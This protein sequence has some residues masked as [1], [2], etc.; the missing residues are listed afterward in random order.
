MKIIILDGY[1]D[2]PSC[3]GVPPYI[4]PY[5]RY[6][7]GAVQDAGFEY[8]YITIDEFRRG[9]IKIKKMNKAQLLVIVGGAV[10]PGKYLRGNPASVSEIWKI[11]NDY[12]GTKILGGPLAKFGFSGERTIKKLQGMFDYI[13]KKDVDAL[14]YDLLTHNLQG[15]RLRSDYEWRNWSILGS[16]VIS[17]HPDYP[18][19]LI[20]EIES[21][22]VCVR[23]H[24]GGCAFCIEPLFGEPQFREVKDI[25]EEVKVLSNAGALNFR[26]GA[27]SCIFTYGSSEVGET[28]IPKPNPKIIESLLLG[29]RK[30][31]PNLQVLHTDNANP[32]VIAEHPEESTRILKTLVKYCTSGNVLALGMESADPEVIKINNLNA[33]PKQ[34][35]FAIELINKYGSLIG[36][37]GMFQFLKDI[38]DSN[39]LLRRINIRQVAPVRRDFKV[40]TKHSD[41]LR[42]KT[43]VREEIDHEMIKRVVPIKSVLRNVYIEKKKGNITFGRQVGTYPILVGIPYPISEGTFRDVIITDHGQRSITGCQYP[44]DVNSA[45]LLALTCLPGIGKKRAARIVRSRPFSSEKEFLSALDDEKVAKNVI[46]YITF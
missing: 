8:T 18:Q 20:I 19:P 7:A 46:G 16:S 35:K 30:S 32:A 22:R 9:S 26:L 40:K 15:D 33:T 3:L 36:E 34:V 25:I 42:F 38:L 6:L 4:S 5:V 44:L 29:I 24:T 39:L 28:E 27:Q 17:Q 37:S 21:Y 10:V 2:E 12:F 23:Y 1:V 11:A 14:V 13:C 45:S 31:A 41:F 43:K